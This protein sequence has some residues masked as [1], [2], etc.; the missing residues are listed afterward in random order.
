MTTKTAKRT[1]IVACGVFKPAIEHL[2]L[3]NRY[4]N[5][6]FTYLPP[7]LH[8]TPQKLEQHL[9]RR[10]TAAQRKDERIICLYGECIPDL[11]NVCQYQGVMKVPGHSCYEMLLGNERFEQFIDETAGTYFLEK[12]LI[13][14]FREYCI[15]PLELDDE[16]MRDCY[17]QHYRKLLYV[18]Q[19][20]D[21]D[22]ISQAHDLA[23]FLELS[24]SVS[25]ADYS[26]LE[27]SLIRLI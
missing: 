22:L 18:R 3:A 23:D 5:L 20:T 15:E 27:K 14:N 10:I 17:F 26:H 6:R 11:S 7:V 8:I 24:L 1:R 21:P 4:P 12:D 25:D 16:E 9:L 2:R 13:L 19:P